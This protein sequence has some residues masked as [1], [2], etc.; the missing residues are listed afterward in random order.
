MAIKIG[1][2]GLGRIGRLVLRLSIE[3][4]EIEV[5]H[6]NDKMDTNTM[7]YLIKYDSVHKQ[8]K[9][10][11]SA[12]D[13]FI[14][15]NG[16]RIKVTQYPSPDQIPWGDSEAEIIIE[17]SGKFKTREMLE[18]HFTGKVRKV[19]LTC[20]AEKE[21]ID[22]MV[23][24]GVNHAQLKPSDR[25]ISNAS[26]TT[27]CVA[28]MLKVIQDAFGIK[29]AFMNTV[30]PYTNNQALLDFPH[31]DLRRS[32]SAAIN[33]IPTTSTAIRAVMQVMPGFERRFDGFA[34]R[35]PVVDGSYVE[36]TAHL[37]K[38]VTVSMI[39]DEF[40]QAS[41]N[42]LKEI[43]EYSEDPLVSTDIINNPHSAIFDSLSVKVLGDDLVRILAWYDNEF[44]YSNRI[45]DLA[46]YLAR[47][48]IADC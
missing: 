20:P 7:S 28:P 10:E 11:I 19:I 22:R 1:I 17:S 6:I 18:A 47:E 5:V 14:L 40:R 45:I 32:R 26:C 12:G 36:L 48:S 37:E 29:K 4:P 27:N 33:I 31:G 3:N 2:N 21:S 23:V 39:R 44:G 41:V 16:R 42:S 13:G 34:T 25:I 30:H 24:I 9:G 15:L 35:V 46:I 43:L 38:N 8:F